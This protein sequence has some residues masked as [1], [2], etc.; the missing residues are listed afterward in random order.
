MALVGLA[1]CNQGTPGGPGATGPPAK[2]PFHGQADNTFNLGV[3]LL[4]TA[5]KQGETKGVSISIKRAKNF[6]EDVALKFA[7]LPR[8]VT[9]NPARP[10]IKHGDTEAKLMLKATDNAALGDF[11]LGVT[12]HP[13]KGADASIEFKINVEKK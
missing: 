12:G 11:T 8:G 9:V 10:I 7:A 13:A 6:D 4:S 2:N 1:G 5:I 3:P